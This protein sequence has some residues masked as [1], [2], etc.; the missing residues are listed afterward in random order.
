[1]IEPRRLS[2]QRAAKLFKN[3]FKP[4][5]KKKIM[6][7]PKWVMFLFYTVRKYILFGTEAWIARPFFF[8]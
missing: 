2:G 7:S 8:Y 6:I 5:R 3:G 1:M 4:F